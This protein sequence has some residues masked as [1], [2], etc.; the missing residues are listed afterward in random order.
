MNSG[1]N[2]I[3]GT[4]GAFAALIGVAVVAHKNQKRKD[5][6]DKSL[7]GEFFDTVEPS[8]KQ[9][10]KKDLTLEDL[11]EKGLISQEDYDKKIK[12]KQKKD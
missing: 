12:E 2:V 1:K 4:L 10:N 3:L 8:Q 6:K 9:K 11:L 5:T 7:W